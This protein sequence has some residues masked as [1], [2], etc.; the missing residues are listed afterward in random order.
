MG[1]TGGGEN[2][3]VWKRRTGDEVEERGLKSRQAAAAHPDVI[4]WQIASSPPSHAH[5]HYYY[6]YYSI[7][8]FCYRLRSTTLYKNLDIS[9]SP[10]LAVLFI[11]NAIMM[12]PPWLRS[13]GCASWLMTLQSRDAAPQHHP[14]KIIRGHQH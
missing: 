2:V 7:V 6:C 13:L 3:C 8:L 12:H 9:T 4:A 5:Q 11:Y 10:I 14:K 1:R